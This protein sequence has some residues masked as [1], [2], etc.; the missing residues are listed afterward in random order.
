MKAT[1]KVNKMVLVDY[2]EYVGLQEKNK[3]G[4][5][6]A[7]RERLFNDNRLSGNVKHT[8]DSYILNT[9]NA[10]QQQQQQR[11]QIETMTKLLSAFK[12]LK[13]TDDSE[14]GRT[15]SPTRDAST[16]TTQ[17][18][19][20]WKNDEEEEEDRD[21]EG[22]GE[23]DSE[24]DPSVQST[25]KPPRRKRK[26]EEVDASRNKKL[27]KRRSPV[28]TRATKDPSSSTSR[29]RAE[30]ER[31]KAK[32]S[33]KHDNSKKKNQTGSGMSLMYANSGGWLHMPFD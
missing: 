3:V 10:M 13:L 6:D 7:Q 20:D 11:A 4:S 30:K 19:G 28:T 23:G 2:N 12:K 8:I 27:A 21:R 9:K 16:F 17:H 31:K 29:K 14:N 24:F 33:S 25:P 1:T 32:N 5:V 18:D 22:D 26:Q 15:T